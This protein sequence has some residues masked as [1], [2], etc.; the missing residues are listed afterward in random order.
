M[1]CQNCILRQRR[2][3]EFL[4][5]KPD[6]WACRKARERLARMTETKES[7]DGTRNPRIRRL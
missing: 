6:G 1:A 4:C 3:V 2:L 7:T 5:K